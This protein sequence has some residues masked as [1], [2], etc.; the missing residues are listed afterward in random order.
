[1]LDI[2]SLGMVVAYLLVILTGAIGVLSLVVLLFREKPNAIRNGRARPK[3]GSPLEEKD[4]PLAPT[5]TEITHQQDR[6][7]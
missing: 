3:T 6:A 5:S 4:M 1:M 2:T 7:A